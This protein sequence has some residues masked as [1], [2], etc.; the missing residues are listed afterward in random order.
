MARTHTRLRVTGT[1]Q[2]VGFRPFVYRHATALGLAG[3]VW[4]DSEGVLIDVEGDEADITELTRILVAEPPPLAPSFRASSPRLRVRPTA[5]RRSPSSRPT[6][7]VVPT[8][9]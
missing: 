4:N 2:G 3:S 9:P 5:R 8:Y 7:A 6:P 1:V